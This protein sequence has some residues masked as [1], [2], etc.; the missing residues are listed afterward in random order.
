M[1]R[2]PSSDPAEP[3]SRGQ[4]TCAC[5]VTSDNGHIAA[6]AHSL[7]RS[8]NSAQLPLSVLTSEAHQCIMILRQRWTMRY[9]D[10]RCVTRSI[11]TTVSLAT[12]L[13]T[14]AE[15]LRVLV[16]LR[17]HDVSRVRM[18]DVCHL[19]SLRRQ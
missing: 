8:P 12:M 7:F 19:L 10:E 1:T 15:I 4:K 17:V 13:L 6:L 2:R 5:Q 3:L 14:D 11:S 9:G 16:H 18:N